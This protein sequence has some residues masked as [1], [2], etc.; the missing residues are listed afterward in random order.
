MFGTDPAKL[1]MALDPRT[2]RVLPPRLA[3]ADRLGCTEYDFEIPQPLYILK[4]SII[5]HGGLT[6]EVRGRVRSRGRST[7]GPPAPQGLFR[8]GGEELKMLKMKHDLN[9]R[10]WVDENDVFGMAALIKAGPPLR[11][12]S[13]HC[14]L[15]KRAPARRAPKRVF[16]GVPLKLL[17]QGAQTW[18][19]SVRVLDA[20]P[21]PRKSILLWFLYF[22]T[23]VALHAEVNKMDSNNLGT[24]EGASRE[25]DACL[26]RQPSS[27]RRS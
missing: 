9:K 14:L 11:R 16:E 13:S 23:D 2:R 21:E 19:G 12:L 8:L 24:E 22:L 26:P 27:S 20:V 18:E 6:T 1:E 5:D 7:H 3:R 15:P 17:E 10:Q 25:P 4:K